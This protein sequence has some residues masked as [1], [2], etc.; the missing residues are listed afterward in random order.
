MTLTCMLCISYLN[1]AIGEGGRGGGPVYVY[2]P[3][4][5]N[6]VGLSYPV[7]SGERLYVVMR[8][9]VGVVYYNCVS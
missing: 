5:H 9:P 6:L 7:G 2:L 1:G 4:Y 3:V 8:I